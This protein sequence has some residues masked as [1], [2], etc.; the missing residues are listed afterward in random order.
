MKSFCIKT[1][2]E[3]IISYLLKDFQKI[4]LNNVFFINRTFKNYQN[5]IIH[6]TGKNISS[7]LSILSDIITNCILYYY[8]PILIKRNINYN[9]FYFDD[10]EKKI[11]ENNCYNCLTNNNEQNYIMN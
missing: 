2:N 1:N 6:Y 8:E 11:I 4:D 3:K 10:I 5:I 9:Y 7:F